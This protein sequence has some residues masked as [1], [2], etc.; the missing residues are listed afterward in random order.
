ML[1]F[2]GFCEECH[3]S[4]SFFQATPYSA[5]IAHRIRWG[6][7]ECRIATL[8]ARRVGA[9]LR[10]KPDARRRLWKLGGAQDK[11][12]RLGVASQ[13]RPHANSR[14]H[15]PHRSKGPI[16]TIRYES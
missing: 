10:Q 4:V 12:H 16:A 11:G 2:S 7:H 8:G 9:R 6:L 13:P 15:G 14:V 3:Y 5:R 1:K